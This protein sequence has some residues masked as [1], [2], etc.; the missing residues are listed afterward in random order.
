[1]VASSPILLIGFF[2]GLGW[3]KLSGKVD[4]WAVRVSLPVTCRPPEMCIIAKFV[5]SQKTNKQK[6]NKKPICDFLTVFFLGSCAKQL[7]TIIV[8]QSVDGS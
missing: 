2:Q 3:A 1:M 6:N 8:L 5:Y 4:V 7:T